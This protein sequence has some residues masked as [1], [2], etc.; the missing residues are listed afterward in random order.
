MSNALQIDNIYYDLDKF[1]IRKDAEVELMKIV[2][3]MESYPKMQIAINSHTDSRQT[4]EYNM[5][6][7]I[8]RAKAAY[9]WLIKNGI[10]ANR[11]SFKG[12]GENKLLNNC[13]DNVDC[14]ETE[15]QKNRRSEFIITKM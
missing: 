7:S 8:N 10:K 15:H 14:T 4:K 5:Q 12:F 11:L 6:L 13:K 9:N 3:L 1:F 2:L